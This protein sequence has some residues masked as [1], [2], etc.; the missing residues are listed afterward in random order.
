VFRNE[1]LTDF[2]IAANRS[3]FAEALD[4]VRRQLGAEVP[5]LIGAEAV[6]ARKQK[7][8]RNPARLSQVVAVVSQADAS[9][10]ERALDQAEAALPAWRNRPA[11]E[12]TAL[13]QKAAEGMRRRRHELAAWQVFEVGKTWVE[14]DADVAEAV[15]YLRYYAEQMLLLEKPAALTEVPGERNLYRR[16]PLGVGVVI[17]PWNFPVAIPTGLTAA[18]L[19]AG[20]V[21]LLKPAEQSSAVAF[22][23]VQILREAGIPPG[24]LQFLPGPGE[25]VGEHLV[26][27]PR[28][29]W[30]GFTGSR[31]VG[32]R[33]L[34]TAAEM[35][36]VQQHVKRVIA[37][38]GGK[39]AIVVDRDADLDEA[40]MG[41][42]ASAFGYSGQKCSACSRVIVLKAIAESFLRRLVE[43]VRSLPIGDPADPSILLGPLVDEQAREKV[44]RYIELGKQEGRIA[45]QG[46]LPP[47]LDG[48]F[49]PPVIVAG[50]VPQSRV[51][52]EEVFGPLLVVLEANSFEQAL[53]IAN[54][55]PYALTGGLYSRSPTH[56]RQAVEELQVGNLYVNRKITGAVVG[57]QPFGGFK[58]S[59]IGYKAGGPDYL[60]QFLQGR[61]VTENT[62]RHGFAPLQE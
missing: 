53:E 12:R 18:A 52:Q 34:R 9:D 27:S 55:V 2:S 40:V 50:V 25:E 49:V 54:A 41:V 14:A 8:R 31:D 11:A 35:A 32:L 48:H 19:A 23:M 26:R 28:V 56:I 58:L 13:L 42:V 44:L 10:A 3:A 37:E 61:T 59:G 30:V 60:L 7:V 57:R 47:G 5:L 62:M 51:A 6:R 46:D 33:I 1:P 21:V 20:N 43:S 36:P 4:R 29:R 16:E 45:L 15:D 38:M 22:Q 39:N 24:V 17:P